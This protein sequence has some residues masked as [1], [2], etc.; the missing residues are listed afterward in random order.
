MAVLNGPGRATIIGTGLIGGSIGFGLRSL[1]WAVSG[2]DADP[3]AAE[4]A[5]QIGAIDEIGIDPASA[6]TFVAV[7]ARQMVTE[8]K[9]ALEATRGA[10]TDVGGVKAGVVADIDDARF[11]GG[12]PMAGS[13]QLGVDGAR[14]DLFEGAVWVLTPVA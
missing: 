14:R 6:I 7:P 13:E 5:L 12:H 4:R 1:G 11:I 2:I 9:R 3:V 8:V 10:V